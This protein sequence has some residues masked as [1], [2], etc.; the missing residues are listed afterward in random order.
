MRPPSSLSRWFLAPPFLLLLY[1][2]AHALSRTL[3]SQSAELDES[4]QLIWS[5]TLAG[6]YG[7]QPPLYT[8]LQWLVFEASGVSVASLALLKNVLLAATYAFVWLAARP[9]MA[10]HLA[11]LAAASM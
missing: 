1:F 8:W 6:G 5:Q 3:I 7:P 9:Y 4:E 10:P 11:V 2:G